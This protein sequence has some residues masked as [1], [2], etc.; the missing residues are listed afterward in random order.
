M[1]R[2]SLPLDY[3]EPHRQLDRRFLHILA[4]LDKWA[5][6]EVEEVRQ[7]IQQDQSDNRKTDVV[8]CLRM[9]RR[10]VVVGEQKAEDQ[11]DGQFIG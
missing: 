6:D 2:S 10:L 3:S 1:L 5:P 8:A 11:V 9:Q 7:H 4:H